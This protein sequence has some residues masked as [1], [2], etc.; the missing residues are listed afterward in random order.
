MDLRICQ[1]SAA[2]PAEPGNIPFRDGVNQSFWRSGIY[3]DFVTPRPPHTTA[4]WRG[5]PCAAAHLTCSDALTDARWIV[6]AW[7][8]DPSS[9]SDLAGASDIR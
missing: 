1:T 5:P 6:A 7:Q 2:S 8:V 4:N 3:T 9:P